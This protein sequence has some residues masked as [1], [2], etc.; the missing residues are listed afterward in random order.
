MK[1][2]EI[3]IHR[4]SGPE[5]RHWTKRFTSLKIENS[6]ENFGAQFKV[7]FPLYNSSWHRQRETR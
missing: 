3:F 6:P 5:Q 1:D 7:N 2:S 4:M